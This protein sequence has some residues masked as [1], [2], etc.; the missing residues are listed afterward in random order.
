MRYLWDFFLAMT[1]RNGSKLSR[2]QELGIYYLSRAEL[3]VLE[4]EAE[5][6]GHRL[7]SDVM[8]GNLTSSE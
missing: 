2:K 8:D 1:S 3:S 7:L 5:V 6:I 4:A